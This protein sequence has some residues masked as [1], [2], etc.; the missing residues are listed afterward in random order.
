MPEILVIK[1][2]SD[3]NLI[4]CT[5]WQ[6]RKI[7]IAFSIKSPPSCSP[8]LPRI[9]IGQPLNESFLG[10]HIYKKH[11]LGYKIISLIYLMLQIFIVSSFK[12][13]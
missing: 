1:S 3:K 6:Q 10:C 7:N 4:L 8:P 13:I 12:L 5:V 9:S 2:Y 11:A